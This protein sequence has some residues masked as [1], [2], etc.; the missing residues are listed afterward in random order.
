MK[1]TALETIQLA[2]F[3]NLI[4]VRVHTDEGLDR[5]GRDVLRRAGGR[6]VSPRD[7]RRPYLLGKDPLQIDLHRGG[8]TAI[9]GFNGTGAEAR[10]NSAIDLALWD[11]FGKATGQPVYQLLG[12][13]QPR[14]PADLQ[15]VRRLPLYPL[16][17]GADRRQLGPADRPVPRAPTRT[18]TPSCTAPTSWRRAC[19]S[20][21]SPA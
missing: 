4:W 21:A 14:A 7:R 10:G 15:H 16:A 8:C 11:L 17:A 6:G 3:P 2:E 19:S 20:R 12:G 9:S 13:A 18:W 1:V 5:A